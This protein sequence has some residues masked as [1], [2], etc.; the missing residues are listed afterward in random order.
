MTHNFV[1]KEP[2]NIPHTALVWHQAIIMF[3]ALRQTPG[4]H[5]FID[6]REV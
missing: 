4:R 5:S 6:N 2:W 1:P 3:P